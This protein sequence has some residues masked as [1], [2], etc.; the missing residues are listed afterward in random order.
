MIKLTR[1]KV[2]V[3]K[4]KVVIGDYKYPRKVDPLETS[5]DISPE[6]YALVFIGDQAH[7]AIS[8]QQQHNNLAFQSMAREALKRGT[9]LATVND[10]TNYHRNVNLALQEKGV[11]YDASGNL[12]EGERLIQAGKAVNNTWAYLNGYFE[13]SQGE[14]GF[15]DLDLVQITGFDG[16]TPITERQPLEEFV[17]DKWADVRGPLNNQ[18][19]YTREADDQ[20][21][22]Q[23]ETVY[24]F[25][26]VIGV[27][28]FVA[29]SDRAYLDCCW[30]PQ[31][32]IPSLGG[33]LRAEGTTREN[34]G[35]K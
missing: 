4:D 34:G 18:G 17:V 16:E 27:A 10:M 35:S 7:Y 23:G 1:E 21:F 14:K 11:L 26:P 13:E 29:Y 32:S 33:F 8:I 15:L 12:I 31:S 19:F 25:K 24:V 5:A 22:V 30:D 2:E 3:E 9:P 20:K 6:N 28:G